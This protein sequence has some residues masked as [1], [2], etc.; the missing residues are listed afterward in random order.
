MIDIRDNEMTR[1]WDDFRGGDDQAYTL[2]YK[3]Y[4]QNL[5]FQGLQ[6][7]QDSELIKD[8]IQEVFLKLYKYRSN[9]SDVNNIKY[10]LLA[11]MRNQLLTAFAKES[12]YS[13]IQ[14]EEL[15]IEEAMYENIED[16]LIAKE[17]FKAIE[18]KVGFFFS[19]L[20]QRQREAMRYRYIECLSSDEICSL[21]ELNYQSLQNILSRSLK[22][23]RQHFKINPSE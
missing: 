23:I 19:L 18:N 22:K 20:T 10:Y 16:D 5:Y 12:R 11:S 1:L 14:P 15:P 13:N 3:K 7:T 8:C 17:E 9:L 21:M 6:L 2:I 4:V